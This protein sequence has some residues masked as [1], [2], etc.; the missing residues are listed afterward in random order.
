MNNNTM[1]EVRVNKLGHSV[2][3][4]V[5]ASPKAK[6]GKTSIPAPSVASFEKTS[7]DAKPK[8]V[9]SPSAETIIKHLNEREVELFGYQSRTVT[10]GYEAGYIQKFSPE[11]RQDMDNFIKH[12]N[13][14][15]HAVMTE[16]IKYDYSEENKIALKIRLLPFMRKVNESS[17]LSYGDSAAQDVDNFYSKY[18][19]KEKMRRSSVDDTHV[20]YFK[21]EHLAWHLWCR[22]SDYDLPHQHYQQL[23]R[24]RANMDIIEPAVTL[25][26]VASKGNNYE[27]DA[28]DNALEVAKFA[29]K[30]PDHIEFIS[31]FVKERGSF[32]Q[33]MLEDLMENGNLALAEGI[34]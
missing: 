7:P 27:M 33:E 32:D 6:S 19:L 29:Q 3:K 17:S 9:R 2:T 34:L 28:V 1:P 11:L 10:Y 23:E 5:S 14:R 30:Y 18:N 26:M 4:H 31:E 25:I 24:L 8:A 21:A 16:M 22:D 20:D 15:D 12:G 13:K